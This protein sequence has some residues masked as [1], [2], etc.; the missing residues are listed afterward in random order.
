[1][2][3]LEIAKIINQIE[4]KTRKLISGQLIGDYKN[5]IK[6][7]GFDF[8]QLREYEEGDDIRYIDWKS[9]AKA[10]QLLVK[11]YLAD[12]NRTF[13]LAVDISASLN[14]GSHALKIDL[15]KNIAAILAFV[16][17]HSKDS[18]GLLLFTDDIEILVPPK[19]NR[20]HILSFLNK[21]FSYNAVSKKTDINCVFKY[22]SQLRSKKIAVCL[23]S[24]FMDKIDRSKLALA[25]QKH[26]IIAFRCLDSQEI[27][28]ADVGF[29]LCQD[30]ETLQQ[31]N[32]DSSSSYV[33][34]SLN[35]WYKEQNDIFKSFRID[36]LDIKTNESFISNL[37]RFLKRTII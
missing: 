6:G 7:S 16:C 12:R 30:S 34:D 37:V 18:V 14:Y 26:E 20:S 2:I 25:I 27:K 3:S 28:F 1:M 21:L 22:I 19:P 17:L 10:N 23:I 11:Q 13:L 31:I 35:R 15:V 36:Y 33:N 5:R 24:D 9:S 8:D 4:L 29:L 32:L